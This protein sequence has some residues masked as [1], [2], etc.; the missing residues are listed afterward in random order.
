MHPKLIKEGRA[1]DIATMSG[2]YKC[3]LTDSG[4][5]KVMVDTSKVQNVKRRLILHFGQKIQFH[6]QHGRNK[7]ELISSPSLNLA[8]IIN[9]VPELTCS[10][11]RL[12]KWPGSGR[13]LCLAA[14]LCSHYP[15]K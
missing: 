12:S 13:H 7:S 5:E 1:Y 9:L 4:M 15:S 8:E 3:H 2:M 10:N 6:Q 11:K 14:V